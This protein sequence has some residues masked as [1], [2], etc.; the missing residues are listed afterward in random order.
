M[1]YSQQRQHARG[2]SPAARDSVRIR[3]VGKGYAGCCPL[4][5]EFSRGVGG[6]KRRARRRLERL[7]GRKVVQHTKRSPRSRSRFGAASLMPSTHLAE[8]R[9]EAEAELRWNSAL[10]PNKNTNGNVHWWSLDRG[11]L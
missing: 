8:A 6:A 5:M 10:L 7:V 1:R 4:T 2:E 9:L 3:E 11:C